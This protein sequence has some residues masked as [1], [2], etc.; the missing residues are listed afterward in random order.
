M[1]RTKAVALPVLDASDDES[2][3]SLLVRQFREFRNRER[4]FNDNRK[5][6][7]LKPYCFEC[8]KKGHTIE[9]CWTLH[10]EHVPWNKKDDDRKDRDK[11]NSRP[12][13]RRD[14]KGR[15][16]KNREKGKE[17]H[18]KKAYKARVGLWGESDDSS[19]SSASESISDDETANVALMA[20]ISS[21]VE[22]VVERAIQA[23]LLRKTPLPE[24]TV[25][26]IPSPTS[27]SSTL[28]ATHGSGH[29][30]YL[31]SNFNYFESTSGS[32]SNTNL[33]AL[34]E[35]ES[36]D[37]LLRDDDE[38]RQRK[39]NNESMILALKEKVTSL[40]LSVR[41]YKAQIKEFQGFS[42]CECHA[43]KSE[44]SLIKVE[45]Q[46]LKFVNESLRKACVSLAPSTPSLDQVLEG[47]KP[48]D[49]TGLGFKKDNGNKPGP[50]R[51]KDQKSKWENNGKVSHG[52][53][54]IYRDYNHGKNVKN[55]QPK[56]GSNNNRVNH[57]AQNTSHRRNNLGRTDCVFKRGP[58]GYFYEV[59][60]YI[61]APYQKRAPKHVYNTQQKPKS[62]VFCAK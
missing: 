51:P 33:D 12:E 37:D 11:R 6:R 28:E 15:D 4:R 17:Y 34:L 21:S 32:S 58:N 19:N 46:N 59:N 1:S 44:T 13:R 5:E 40:E 47:Q 10:P 48:N 20:E 42:K 29:E 57:F 9:T 41:S 16:E 18:K 53:A 61:D 8:N 52:N 62:N 50:S 35:L 24:P 31:N 49:K 22:D 43:L 7:N 3:M 36:F 23:M 30:V 2:E 39:E 27:P 14:V 54:F 38:H 25:I 55:D 60:N 45:L 56:N 26:P